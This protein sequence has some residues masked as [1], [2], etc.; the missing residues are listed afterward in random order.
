V[1]DVEFEE[2]V[3]LRDVARQLTTGKGKIR[4]LLAAS[5]GGGGDSDN[6]GINGSGGG[7]TRILSAPV[8]QTT[9]RPVAT[10]RPPREPIVSFCA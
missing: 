2:W 9:F 4:L 5:G 8:P 6:N 7:G 3:A 10:A 1:W